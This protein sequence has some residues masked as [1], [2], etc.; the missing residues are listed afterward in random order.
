MDHTDQAAHNSVKMT[1]REG[2]G[3]KDTEK[4]GGKVH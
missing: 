2:E 4:D 1:G 3:Q